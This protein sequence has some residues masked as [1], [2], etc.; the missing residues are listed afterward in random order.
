MQYFIAGILVVLAYRLGQIEKN[1]KSKDTT[2]K[3]C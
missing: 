1:G 2:T 3:N